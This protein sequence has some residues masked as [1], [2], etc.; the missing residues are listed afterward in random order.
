MNINKNTLNDSLLY[1]RY[2]VKYKTNIKKNELENHIFYIN[3]FLKNYK[4]NNS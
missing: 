2:I 1:S 4:K 3:G